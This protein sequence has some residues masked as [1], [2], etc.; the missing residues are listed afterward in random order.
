M[1]PYP[2][3]ARSLSLR[4][5]PLA[6]LPLLAAC[7][8]PR[9]AL[10]QYAV[11]TQ[12][13][14]EGIPVPATIATTTGTV[15]LPTS[16]VHQD[17]VSVRLDTAIGI[18]N[19]PTTVTQLYDGPSRPLSVRDVVLDTLANNRSIKIEGY[20]LRIAEFDVPVNKGI[21]DLLI[22]GQA[23]YERI[24]E[25]SS[26]SGG[27]FNQGNTNSRTT[28]GE[29]NLSQ[30][31]PTGGTFELFSSLVRSRSAFNSVSF[32]PLAVPPFFSFG[33]TNGVS[34]DYRAGL[35]AGITQPLLRGFGPTVTNAEIRIAQFEQQGAAADFEATVEQALYDALETYWTLI[36][37]IEAY[38]VRIVS[39]S[40]ARDLLRVNQ[41]KYNAGVLAQTEVLQAEAAAEDRRDLLIRQR[42]NV[43]DLE[44]QLKRLIHL[45]ENGP[46]WGLQIQPTQ[47]FAWRDVQLDAE[48]MIEVALSQRAELRRAQS[49]IDKA[50]LNLRVARNRIMPQVDLFARA[51]ATGLDD[52]ASGS[53]GEADNG[54]DINYSTGVQF[55]YPLQNRRAR[56]QLRQASASQDQAAENYADVEEQIITEVRQAARALLTSRERIDVTLSQVRA[57]QAK[58]ASETKR[59]DVGIS[60]AF[61]VLDFQEDLA[62]AALQHLQAVVDFNIALLRLERARGTLLE[63]LGVGVTGTELEPAAKPVIFPV[64]LR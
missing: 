27:L 24:D 38:K 7:S 52:N 60:T 55:S 61:Q 8:T 6:L 12:R 43:R 9:T 2:V 25:Q 11:D 16:A 44:D 48:Q 41:A 59:L 1:L 58:L 10:P 13:L 3:L 26:Q 4:L 20:D 40:A 45:R 64:G 14:D 23:S 17:P 31:L 57:E 32:T 49:T 37:N 46:E 22:S 62:D 47:S 28:R 39:Y 63:T 50:E 33:S 30:L 5:L 53:F 42:Q 36:G 54:D 51:E 15:T 29:L 21:Y 35:G 18:E 19:L 34:R 56:Y